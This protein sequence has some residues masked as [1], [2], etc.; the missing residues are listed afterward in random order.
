MK[1][2]K[3]VVSASFSDN[4]TLISFLHWKLEL[5]EMIKDAF[6]FLTSLVVVVVVFYAEASK[7]FNNVGS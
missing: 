5:N 1:V 2:L 4:F 3:Y 6:F 7:E